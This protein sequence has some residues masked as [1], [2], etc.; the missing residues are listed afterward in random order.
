MAQAGQNQAGGT[1]KK[2]IVR[3]ADGELY[4]LIEG[5]APKKLAPDEAQKLTKILQDAQN[6]LLDSVKNQIP[7]IGD[8]AIFIVLPEDK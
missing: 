5:E 6:H 1:P 4:L 8:S 2:K 3:G 7:S